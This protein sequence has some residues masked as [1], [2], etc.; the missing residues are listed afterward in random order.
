MFT[1]REINKL[2]NTILQAKYANLSESQ[3]RTNIMNTIKTTKKQAQLLARYEIQR[4]RS[5]T[6]NEYYSL[7]KMQSKYEKV[8]ANF[9]FYSFWIC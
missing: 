1:K 2:K 3:L 8:F 6:L 7:P 4:L 5:I 9:L